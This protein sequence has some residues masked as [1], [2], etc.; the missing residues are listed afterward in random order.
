MFESGWLDEEETR[1]T[2]FN[3][4]D[5]EEYVL[6]PHTAV[7]VGVYDDYSPETGDAT[8]AV[9]VSTASPYKFPCDVYNAIAEAKETDPVKAVKKLHAF[10]AAECPESILR[11]TSL[12]VRHTTVIEKD[13]AEQAVFD[14]VEGRR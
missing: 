2:M 3:Y 10:T 9:I 1:D 4:Y 8:P 7:A 5:L 13:G 6:D 11:L 14:F 12:P